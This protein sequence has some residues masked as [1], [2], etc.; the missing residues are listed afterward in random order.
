MGIEPQV[1]QGKVALTDPLK[2]A[3]DP[4][5]QGHQVQAP[6]KGL[7]VT[8]SLAK[9]LQVQQNQKFNPDNS[10]VLGNL[11]DPDNLQVQGSLL[12]QGIEVA[13]SILTSLLT[14]QGVG[15][16]QGLPVVAL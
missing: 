16:I 5:R 13:P 4:K 9:G 10:Q 11:L 3:T 6:S 12:V 1:Q 8:S 7:V 14:V 15:I 2:V